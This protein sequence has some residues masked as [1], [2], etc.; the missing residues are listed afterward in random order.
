MAQKYRHNQG[1]SRPHLHLAPNDRRMSPSY[2][3]AGGQRHELQTPTHHGSG[4][5]SLHATPTA[6]R[7]GA[8]RSDWSSPNLPRAEPRNHVSPFDRAATQPL[9]LSADGPLSHTPDLF[10]DYLDGDWNGEPI[11]RPVSAPPN[12]ELNADS[13]F[14]FS[15]AYSKAFQG[16]TPV[17]GERDGLY[18]MFPF[19][20]GDSPQTD[21]QTVMSRAHHRGNVQ[22]LDRHTSSGGS[23]VGRTPLATPT[24]A[25]T[26]SR[27]A[28]QGTRS[29][30]PTM[31]STDSW[32]PISLGPVRFDDFI[33]I[34]F[35]RY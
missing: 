19:E 25:S 24:S 35:E 11:P 5:V 20:E 3:Q 15:A 21:L 33:V 4:S 29:A 13:L 34:L 8:I 23:G 28:I 1:D 26:G 17:H 9:S 22:I 27:H 14:A 2:E 7:P 16:G 18:D 12:L 10:G 30:A 6:A 32:G 31:R